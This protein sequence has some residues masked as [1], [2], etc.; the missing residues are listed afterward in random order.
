MSNR[1]QFS[2][3]SYDKDLASYAC[4]Q[5]ARPLQSLAESDLTLTEF[6]LLDVYLARI[7]S[8]RPEKRAVTIER[9]ELEELLGLS[10]IRKDDLNKRL[11]HLFQ[12]V[13][14]NDDNKRNGFILINLFEK[15]EA[16][17]D[18][19]GQWQITLTCTPSAREYIF[20]IET[21]GYLRYRL[22]NVINLTSRYSYVLYLYVLDN[23]FRSKWKISVEELKELLNCKAERYD[24][25]KFFNAE[26]I[27]KSCMEINQKTDLRFT[28]KP[29]RKGRKI[30]EIEFTICVVDGSGKTIQETRK[31]P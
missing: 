14:V 23:K 24:V 31:E 21:I 16:E 7:D 13:K 4:I 26:I 22:K 20:N 5:K 15:A 1:I 11:R 27:K 8:H 25:F 3:I 30:V 2:E 6:K 29:I 10:Q 12:T 17:Q 19:N 9:G 28:Y 18:E